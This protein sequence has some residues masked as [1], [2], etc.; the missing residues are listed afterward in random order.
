VK[1]KEW[2]KKR[3][4]GV[5]KKQKLFFGNNCSD[6]SFDD[7]T[8]FFICTKNNFRKT[9]VPFYVRQLLLSSQIKSIKATTYTKNHHF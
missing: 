6:I 4:L 9:P 5:L 3:Y 7:F 1:W 8:I 2:L